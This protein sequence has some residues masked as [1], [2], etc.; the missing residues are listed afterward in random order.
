MVVVGAQVGDG[1]LRVGRAFFEFG[2]QDGVDPDIVAC[3]RPVGMG[4]LGEVANGSMTIERSSL[5]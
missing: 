5:R 1:L 2:N 3:Q 4:L